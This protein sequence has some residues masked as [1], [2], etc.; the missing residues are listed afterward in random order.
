MRAKTAERLGRSACI[1]IVL[2]CAVALPLR[3]Q[4]DKPWVDPPA[5]LDPPT[6][7]QSSSP[8]TAPAQT[9]E[10]APQTAPSTEPPP[11]AQS[12]VPPRPAVELSPE[13][14]APKSPR[15][16]ARDAA[17]RDSRPSMDGGN[18]G[19]VRSSRLPSPPEITLGLRAEQ[20]AL[21]YL[22]FWSAPNAVTLAR[23]PAFYGPEV[24][25]HGQRMSIKAL[26]EDK[27]RFARR[28]PD[29]QYQ[30]RRETMRIA[31]DV[32]AEMCN[33]RTIVNFVAASPERRRRSQGAITL[34]LDISFA[35]GLP[36]I[37][38][39]SSRVIARGAAD[40]D[41]YDE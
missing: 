8:G 39:E 40:G 9:P 11:R 14:P 38:N 28:W 20:L 2:L 12:A 21:D 33:L 18:Q 35:D 37:V 30:P 13:A 25:F 7:P 29:R 4:T 41:V 24:V 6:A 15:P 16:A 36:I 3:A 10:A 22:S 17:P 26:M 1:A 32:A 23:M 27:R 19:N 5:R 31:C 34:A